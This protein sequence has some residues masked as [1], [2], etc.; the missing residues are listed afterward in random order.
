MNSHVRLRRRVHHLLNPGDKASRLS[1]TVNLFVIFLILVNVISASLETVQDFY[2]AYRPYFLAVEVFSVGVFTLEYLLRFWSAR[3]NSLYKT[4]RGF[5]FS[6]DSII[7]ILAVMPF[8]LGFVFGIDLRALIALR[9]LRL[10]KLIRYFQ[11]L[12]ILGAV[13]KAEFRGFMAAMFVLV[14]LVFVAATG[15]YFFERNAQPE[16]FGSIPQSMWWAIVT[17]TTLGYGDVIPVTVAGR[18]FAALITVMS[19]GTV[20]L[21]AGMLASRFSEELKKRKNLMD[22]HITALSASGETPDSQTLEKLRSE[23]CISD[24]DLQHLLAHQQKNATV[25]PLCKRSIDDR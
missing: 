14:I 23:L 17:L 16:V 6:V 18:I 4:R 3:E 19:I 11:P 22:G 25:C 15:I 10:L 21:P 8:Y 13:I 1:Q 2:V 5:F 12:A 9:L 20:A 7:D 24:D